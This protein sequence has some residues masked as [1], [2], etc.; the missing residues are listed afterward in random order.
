[1]EWLEVP[2]KLEQART[3][4]SKESQ[5]K[6]TASFTSSFKLYIKI[7]IWPVIGM[8]LQK[9]LTDIDELFKIKAFN[10]EID[11]NKICFEKHYKELN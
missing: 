7:T 8:A 10:Y 6:E 11:T 9:N 3:G 4:W 1:M 2:N 5:L